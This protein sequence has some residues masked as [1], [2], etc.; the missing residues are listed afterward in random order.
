MWLRILVLL[1]MSAVVV[2]QEKSPD[3]AP[4]DNDFV[5]KE[6]GSSCSLA[7]QWTP[8]T[9][10]LN[11]DGVEDVVIVAHCKNPL[12]DQGEKDFKV[13]DPYNSFYGYGNPKITSQMGPNDPKLQGI[14]VLVIHGSG[15]SGWR[16][17]TPQAK[18]V[19]INLA[20]K[21]ITVKKMR[22]KKKKTTTAIYVEEAGADQMTSVIFWDG[23]KYRYEP[24]GSSM[25]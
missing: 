14:D 9:G 24:L 18:F 3:P 12:I 22:V 15:P 13:I 17:P 4:A 19:I 1:L 8:V 16:S 10:D 5:Q 11:G 6:F 25:E 21:R 7:P 2:A 20:L 23:K